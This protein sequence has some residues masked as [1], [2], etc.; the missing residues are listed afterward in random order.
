MNTKSNIEVLTLDREKASKLAGKYRPGHSKA[1]PKKLTEIPNSLLSAE[2][3]DMFVK[4]TGLI[5]PYYSGGGRKSRLKK[6]SYEGRI[7]GRA[8]IFNDDSSPCQIFDRDKHTHLKVPKNSIVFV[9]SDIDFRLPEF[10]ALRFNLQIRHVHRGLLLGTG[11]LVD[12]GYW[13]KLCIPLHNLTNEDYLI[14]RDEGIIWL[15]FTKTT[16]P[17]SAEKSPL[18][19]PPLGIE[20]EGFFDIVKFLEKASQIYGFGKE[21]S[22]VP[23]RSSLPLLI[24]KSEKAVAASAKNASDA[25]DDA[26]KFKRLSFFGALGGFIGLIALVYA[27]AS[28]QWTYLNKVEQMQNE[29]IELKNEVER[30]KSK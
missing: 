6:A 9:E 8:F 25:A 24:S 23:I 15:E 12:P 30:L 1:L 18:G 5:A 4:E 29:I 19:R 10:I 22:K 21:R 14:P 20:H 3:I 27:V 28:L 26:K 13:G 7:G 16:S 2:H 11:P 17:K